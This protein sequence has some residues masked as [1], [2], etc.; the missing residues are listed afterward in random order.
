MF[1]ALAALIMS[2]VSILSYF[3]DGQ[4]GVALLAAIVAI[5]LA[6]KANDYL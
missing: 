3:R 2:L 6:F 4:L 1:W 5:V